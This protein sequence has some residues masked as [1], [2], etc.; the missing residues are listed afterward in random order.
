MVEL[1]EANLME[2]IDGTTPCRVYF[3]KD[4]P[5]PG[6]SKEK[7]EIEASGPLI[8]DVGHLSAVGLHQSWLACRVFDEEVLKEW[9]KIAKM[10]KGDTMEG[11]TATNRTNGISQYYKSFR[12]TSGARK[13]QMDGVAMIPPQ[14]EKGPSIHLGE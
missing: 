4:K 6:S 11:V 9:G 3:T 1:N 7:F 5:T 10:L 8:L 13:L 12:H 2:A 14:G